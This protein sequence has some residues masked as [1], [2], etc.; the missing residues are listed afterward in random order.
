MKENQDMGRLPSVSDSGAGEVQNTPPALPEIEG[1]QILSLLG[2]GGMG[3]VWRAV[4]L[5]TRREV[6]LKFMDRNVFASPEARLRFEREV[7]LTASLEH[8]NIAR[9]YAS[10]M[11]HS[12]YYYAMELLDGV[13]LD[14]YVENNRLTK[15]QI[16][17]LMGVVCRAVQHAH[18]QGIIHRDLKP[19]N[20]LITADGEPHVLDFGLAKDILGRDSGDTA[21]SIDGSAAGTPAYMSPEQASGEFSQVD[22]RSDVYSLGVILFR[23]LIGRSPHNLSG[24]RYEVLRRVAEE[25]VARPRAVAKHRVNRELEAVLLKALARNTEDRYASAGALGEDIHRYLSGEPVVAKT[26]T[27]AYF[28][29]KRIQK[30]KV[31]V[32]IGGGVLAVLFIMAIFSYVRIAAERNLAEAERARAVASAQEAERQRTRAEIEATRAKEQSDSAQRSLYFNMIALADRELQRGNIA[33]VRD[34]LRRCLSDLRGWEWYRIR[35]LCDL[36]R[37]TLSGHGSDVVSVAFSPDGKRILSGSLDGTLKIWN[38]GT[39]EETTTLR[40]HKGPVN[41]TTFSPDSKLVISGSRDRTV[42]VWNATTGEEKIT[43]MH[44]DSVLTVAFAP[45]GKWFASGSRTLL[46]IWDARTGANLATFHPHGES[47][48]PLVD[49]VYSISISP[50]SKMVATTGTSDNVVRVWEAVTGKLNLA[51]RGHDGFVYSVA[52]SPDGK[53]IVS[54]SDDRTIRVWDVEKGSEVMGLKGHLDAVASVAYSP[55]SKRIA[56]AG[57]HDQTVRLWDAETGEPRLVLRGHDKAVY[58]V[59]FSPDGKQAVSGSED[60]TIKVWDILEEPGAITLR[61]H[62]RPVTSVGFS[63]DGR[64][65]VSAG[66]DQRIRVWDAKKGKELLTISGHTDPC[67]SV[68]FSPDGKRIVSTGWDRKAKVWDAVT[69]SG[70]MTLSGH[71][72]P[73][74]SVAFSPKGN[75]IISGSSDKTL[76]VWGAVTGEEKMTLSGHAEGVQSVTFSP[77]DKWIASGSEDGTVILWDTATGKEK[78]TLHAHSGKVRSVAFSPD[79]TLLVSAG[80]DGALKIWKVCTGVEL[81]TLCGHSRGVRSAIFSPDGKRIISAGNDTVIRLWDVRTK[82]TVL[83]LA[84]H[85]G[86]VNSLAFSPDGRTI[87]S[88]GFDNMV[89]IWDSGLWDD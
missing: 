8:P 73:I 53:R 12:A 5:S 2:R 76:R 11:H 87:V 16:L 31:P 29:R 36:S 43:G 74:F 9:V 80:D 68:A 14:K 89:K 21:V 13:R 67:T 71:T 28:L 85:K 70:I 62:D 6:A 72:G 32:A 51:L 52:F 66:W 1:Y 65:I 57:G 64:R 54:A 78:L 34:L 82:T 30:H 88:G 7:E 49:R 17:E 56:S 84:G 86:R 58:S 19:S 38:A 40:G 50:D 41:C 79:S 4:Q 81:M 75:R 20:I 59:A 15:R 69:G 63:P 61:G 77:N 23:L 3:T 37:L 39:G 24:T 44:P 18:Q 60:R 10:G 45:N 46:K 83:V 55:D 22:T 25:E 27:T 33:Q 47:K 35:H 26:P 48:N 42:K